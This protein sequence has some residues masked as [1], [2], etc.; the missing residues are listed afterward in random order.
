MSDRILGGIGLL[1]AAFYIW[2]AQL[3][4]LSFISDPVGPRSFPTIIGALLGLSSLAILIRP[5]AEP[6]W[7]AFGR[8]A[9]IAASVAVLTAYAVLLPDLGFLIAT[10]LAAAYLGWR[11]G[12]APLWAFVTG[13]GTAVGIYVVFNLILGLSLAKGPFGF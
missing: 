6:H 13:L 2:Q 4:Q 9:E 3:I 8:L 11:L 10:T 12:T 5:D 7:P 1:L